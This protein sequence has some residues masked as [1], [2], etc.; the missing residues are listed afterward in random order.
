[1]S[2]TPT[3]VNP[4]GDPSKEGGALRSQDLRTTGDPTSL[5]GSD[6]ARRPRHR[7]RLAGQRQRRERRRQRGAHHRLRL[8]QPVP[9]H[10]SDPTA[11]VWIGDVG[12]GVWE[13]INKITD[14]DAAPR[15]F[16][17]P[18]Y[19]G[20]GS[21]GQYASASVGI[22]LC[23]SLTSQQFAAYRYNHDDNIVGGDGCTP[24]QQ[25]D[26][27]ARVPAVVEQ[28]PESYDDG[29]FF[30]DYSRKCIWFAP[31]SGGNPDFGNI[32]RFANL[33]RTSRDDRRFGLPRD[34]ARPA[35]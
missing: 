10:A 16:G 32:S 14:P 22:S 9:H 1:M 19:E 11:N 24:G 33:R 20:D 28:L 3:P 2:N 13:E 8:A 27:R 4:C 30:T 31:N 35:T 6:P 18:C 26:L 12:W 5:D 23:T 29:L 25:L 7:R 34:H 17:W 21:N 15:N